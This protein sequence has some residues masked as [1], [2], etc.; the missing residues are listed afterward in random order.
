MWLP[1]DQ[2]T[3]EDTWSVVGMRGKGSQDFIVD[4]V[5]VPAAHTCFIGG[6]RLKQVRSIIRG[7]SLRRSFPLSLRIRSALRVAPSTR[8]SNWLLVRVRDALHRRAAGFVQARLAEAE[9]ILNGARAF[10]VDAVGTLWEA[11]CSDSSD[12]SIAIAQARLA[13]VHAMHEAVRA[14]DL[15]F[16]AAGTNAIYCRNPLERYFRDIH[17]A[18]QH[19]SAF[20]AQYESAGKVLMGLRPAD[21]G[22]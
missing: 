3:I 17:V 14:V 2:A 1:P 10:V 12:L 4:D 20:P 16:H 5:F 6:R 11:V 18:V 8:S 7:R 22:W 15:V 9:A 21:V 13:I 19:N